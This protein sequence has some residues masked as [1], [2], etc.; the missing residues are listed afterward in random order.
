MNKDGSQSQ[1]KQS[2]HLK[3]ISA[4]GKVRFEEAEEGKQ[5]LWEA[6]GHTEK[7]GRAGGYDRPEVG[8]GSPGRQVSR[9]PKS[10]RHVEVT[11]GTQSLRSKTSGHIQWPLAQELVAGHGHQ[12]KAG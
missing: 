4:P 6:R 9:D 3:A 11:Q 1:A 8:S 2:R 12:N 5:S 10:R 7:M